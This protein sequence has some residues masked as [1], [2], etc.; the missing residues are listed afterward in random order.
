MI[1][2]INLRH[3]DI[4]WLF[5][6]LFIFRQQV[7]K[8]TYPNG[9]M[10][11][12]FSTGLHYSKYLQHKLKTII[13]DNFNE[14]DET[15]WLILDPTKRQIEM[16]TLIGKHKYVDHDFNELDLDWRMENY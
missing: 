7:Y 16:S 5:N 4:V 1:D 6:N 8:L 11:E 10:L 9:G 13:S 3:A 2:Q 14:I 15:L 12:G